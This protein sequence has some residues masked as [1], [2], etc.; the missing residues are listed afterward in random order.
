MNELPALTCSEV[1]PKESCTLPTDSE[2][3]PVDVVRVL[4]NATLDVVTI[5]RP[6]GVRNLQVVLDV[7][8]PLR[9]IG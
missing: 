7:T 2:E 8:P 1:L 9:V 3:V 5:P 6:G 4:P